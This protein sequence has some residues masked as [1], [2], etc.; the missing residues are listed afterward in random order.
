MK[1]IIKYDSPDSAKYVKNIEGWVSK[2]GKFFG[3]DEHI[4]RWDGCT[5]V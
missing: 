1:E 3:K 4:A 5:H 2:N